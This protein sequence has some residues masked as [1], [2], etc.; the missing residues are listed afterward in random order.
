VY[1]G[2]PWWFID[3]PEAIRRFR[4]AVTETA[5]FSRTSGFIDD[6]RAF[7][8]IPARH[9]MSRRLDCGFL[10]RLVAE[11][12]LDEDEAAGHRHTTSLPTNPRDRSSSYEHAAAAVDAHLTHAHIDATGRR[13]RLRRATDGRPVAPVRIVHLGL[14]NFFRAHQCWFTETRTGR[15][16]LGDRRLHRHGPG[17]ADVSWPQQDNLYTLVVNQPEQAAPGSHLEHRRGPRVRRPRPRGWATSPHPALVDRHE[18]GDRGRLSP[19]RV[20]RPRPHRPRRR[21]RHR[22]MLR[23]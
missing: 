14:G 20:G 7:C 2:V 6:T 17:P 16:R 21:R 12:R 1:A 4:G 22:C 23:V 11:H 15:R 8:S 5:G 13:T 10:A 3:A 19:Q 9:D 18:H